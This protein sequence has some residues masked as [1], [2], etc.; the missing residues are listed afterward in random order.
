[1]SDLGST[2]GLNLVGS[3]V[4]GADTGDRVL[5]AGASETLCLKV[6]LPFA[7]DNTYQGAT[8]TAT[9]NFVAEQ[10]KNN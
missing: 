6:M 2:T 3:P 8:T 5:A 4:S 1:M 9:F 7:T 10:T